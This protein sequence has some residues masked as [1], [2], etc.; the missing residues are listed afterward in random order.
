MEVPMDPS[1]FNTQ[2]VEIVPPQGSPKEGWFPDA[3]GSTPPGTLRC[4]DGQAWTGELHSQESQPLVHG[5]AA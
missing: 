2:M 1:T 5:A 4:W 3:S